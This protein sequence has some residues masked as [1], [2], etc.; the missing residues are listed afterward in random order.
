MHQ[1]LF[2]LFHS[3]AIYESKEKFTLMHKTKAKLKEMAQIHAQ[4]FVDVV[5]QLLQRPFG[6]R[7][8]AD[9]K[10]TVKQPRP[11]PK[12]KIKTGG[13]SFQLEL[14]SKKDWFCG[15]V[16]RNGLFCRLCLLFT[17]GVSQSWTEIGYT[18]LR[19]PLPDSKKH[20][21]SKSYLEAYK[22]LKTF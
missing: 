6:S 16:I 19:N 17:P 22:I 11:M 7:S 18:N 10:L 12:L 14:Y 2:L 4:P 5:V 9:Q 8:I 15:S 13:R 3:V 20:E 1:S 21:K